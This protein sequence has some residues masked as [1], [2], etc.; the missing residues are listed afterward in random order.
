MLSKDQC[1]GKEDY[2]HFLYFVL[3]YNMLSNTVEPVY[4]EHLRE[5]KK[6]SM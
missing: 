6:C 4:I 2:L 5:M 3:F 1:S